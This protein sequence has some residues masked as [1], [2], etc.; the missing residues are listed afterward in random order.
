MTL[1]DLFRTQTSKEVQTKYEKAEKSE[2]Y[3]KWQKNN[4]LTQSNET[5]R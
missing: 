3:Y 5:R 4:T 1:K 2:I